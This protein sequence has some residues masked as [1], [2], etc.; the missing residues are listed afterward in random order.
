MNYRFQEIMK[1]VV[2]GFLLI[3]FIKL[4]NSAY[5]IE[6]YGEVGN[7]I[8]RVQPLSNT[9]LVLVL[10]FVAF[11]IGYLVN[12]V[13]SFCERKSYEFYIIDRPSHKLLKNE[14]MFSKEQ[15]LKLVSL[16][17][18]PD[19]YNICRKQAGLIFK[20]V[21]EIHQRSHDVDEF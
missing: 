4:F 2:P 16:I 14:K 19:E 15:R 9:L 13:A 8:N 17:N 6:L 10:P 7:V 12:M 3:I 20:K 11:I 1:M 21:K 18:H 5:G